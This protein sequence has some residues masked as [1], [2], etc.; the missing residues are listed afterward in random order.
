MSS[1]HHL[2]KLINHKI[3]IT[4]WLVTLLMILAFRG[5]SSK[6]FFSNSSDMMDTCPIENKAFQHGE[7]MIYKVFYNWGFVWIPA[8]EVTFSVE[9]S[10]QDFHLSVVGETYK[11]YDWFFKVRDYYDTWIDKRTLLP[12]V[13]IRDITEGGYTLYD[14]NQFDQEANTVVN[15]RGRRLETIKENNFFQIENCMHDMLSIVYWARNLS[16]ENY[17]QGQKISIKIFAD[18]KTWALSVKY[19]GEEKGHK[20]R[21]LGDFNTLK[22]SPEVIEGTVFPKNAQV[23]VWVSDDQ[24]RVPLVIE[25]P[26]SIGSAKAILKSYKGLRYDF[27]AKMD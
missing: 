5:P 4:I 12:N 10:T 21:G 9:E 18:K 23:N 14:K 1:L 22:F 3:G 15:L 19:L 25:S 13:S 16:F 20:V 17:Q 24:N 11:S 27:S 26:L 8:G 7:E 2:Q 6:E